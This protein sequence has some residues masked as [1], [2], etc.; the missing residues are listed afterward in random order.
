MVDF[1]ENWIK[2]DKADVTTTMEMLSI[3]WDPYQG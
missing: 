3:S 2:K 1:K